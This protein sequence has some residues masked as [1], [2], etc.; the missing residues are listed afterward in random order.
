MI[1]FDTQRLHVRNWRD[2]DLDAYAA[3][4]ADPQVM[5]LFER[6][7]DRLEAARRLARMRREGARG[8]GF[9]PAFRRDTGAMV[10]FAGLLDVTHPLLPNHR[11]VEVGWSL[12]PDHWGRGY[13]TELAVAWLARGFA[14]PPGGLGRR[15]IVAFCSVPNAASQAVARRAGMVPV[16][17]FDHPEVHQAHIRPHVLLEARAETWSPPPRPTGTGTATGTGTGT[18]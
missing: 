1:P 6:R 18:G 12:A 7:H 11:G 2:D 13:A 9:M 4:L 14:D 15:R 17:T 16:G 8:Y 3:M 10:G 5:R